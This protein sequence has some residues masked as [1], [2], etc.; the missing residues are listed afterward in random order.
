MPSQYSFDLRSFL[1]F[2]PK[3][4]VS[5]LPFFR[6][7]A[8]EGVNYGCLTGNTKRLTHVNTFDLL[9]PLKSTSLP[10]TEICS[11]EFTLRCLILMQESSVERI[12]LGN[13]SCTSAGP[14]RVI[15]SIL[16]CLMSM[17]VPVPMKKVLYGLPGR[18]NQRHFDIPLGPDSRTLDLQEF[19]AERTQL[20]ASH[21]YFWVLIQISK[22]W[23]KSFFG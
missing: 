22:T 15:K 21:P 20:F 17:N 5:Q 14:W 19:T 23:S 2:F 7:S 8:G 12:H 6:G 13:W 1:S 11:T 16:A 3:K 18:I 10:Y 4:V 9:P